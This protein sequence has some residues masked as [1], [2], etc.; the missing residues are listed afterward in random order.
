MYTFMHKSEDGTV[1]TISFEATFL[2]HVLYN[3]TQ[4]LQGTGFSWV[5][6][7]SIWDNTGRDVHQDYQPNDGVV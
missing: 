5:E 1:N 3:F 6:G 2:P 7:T 4:F